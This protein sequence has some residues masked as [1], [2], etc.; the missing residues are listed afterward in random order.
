MKENASSFP[1]EN[2]TMNKQHITP[3]RHIQYIVKNLTRGALTAAAALT[4]LSVGS[5]SF[6]DAPV[7]LAPPNQASAAQPIDSTAGSA[8]QDS[9]FQWTEI[10]QNQRVPLNRAVFDQNGYQLFDTAGETVMVPF[11]N[12]NLYVMKFAPSDDGTLYLINAGDAPVLYVPKGGYL[13]NAS[14][15]GAR[16]YPFPDDFQPAQPVFLGVAPSWNAFLSIGW[17]PDL[18]IRGGYWGRS[19]FISGGVFLPSVGLAFEIGGHH[20]DGWEPYHAYVSVH[21]DRFRFGDA[22][23]FSRPHVFQGAGQRYGYDGERDDNR[24]FQSSDHGRSS[25]GHVFHGGRGGDSHGGRH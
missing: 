7:T 8:N 17:A 5:R 21:P 4:L 6:A 13:E 3:K 11:T 10:P 2:R 14:Q 23:H 22:D 16:W 9:V 18:V 19:S 25:G 1:S 24:G 20:Y 12:N 15:P